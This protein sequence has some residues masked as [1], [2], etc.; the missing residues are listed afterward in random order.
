MKALALLMGILISG[1][2]LALTC[3]SEVNSAKKLKI[4]QLHGNLVK[5]EA[6]IRTT[7]DVFA[8]SV[9]KSF[10]FED[11]YT[12]YNQEGVQHSLIVSKTPSFPT[13]RARVC[14]DPSPSEITAKLTSGE[15]NE[16]FTCL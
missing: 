4:E 13:C 15:E 7:T 8:G 1:Q 12:L 9:E 6:Y 11:V 10:F 16:Y 3:T 14:H 2:T 5:A